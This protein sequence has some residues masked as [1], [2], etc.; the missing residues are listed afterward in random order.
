MLMKRLFGPLAFAALVMMVAP[1]GRADV[2]TYD[3]SLVSPPGFYNGS[4]NA[5]SNFTVDTAGDLELGLS[6]IQRFVGPIDP[7]AGSNVYTVTPSAGPLANWDFAFSV[8][9]QAGGGTAVLGDDLYSLTVQDITASLNGPTFDPV[10]IITD[11]SGYGSSGKTAGVN[12]STEWGAQNDEN[13][14]FAGFLPGFNSNNPDLYKITLS[15]FTQS[16]VLI[17]SV[18]V[19]AN[20]QATPEPK[21]LS[22]IGLGM[23]A[24]VLIARFVNPVKKELGKT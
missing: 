7:G 19:Y 10:R 8:N 11:D 2:V 15:A 22:L 16:D 21:Y 9:T 3:T 6:I 14:G 24:L 12:L 1:S 5:N 17:G 13:L 20:A 18:S 4:G 23:F